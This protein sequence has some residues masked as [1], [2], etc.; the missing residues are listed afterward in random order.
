MCRQA[1]LLF[2]RQGTLVAQRFDLSRGEV[3]GDS[4]SVGADPV[5]FD[6]NFNFG[7]FSFRNRF[8]GVSHGS[9]SERR[10]LVWFDRNGKTLGTVG[11]P[12]DNR[13]SFPQISPDGHRVAVYR[14]VQDNTD[15]WILDG[16]RATRFTFDAALDRY[17]TWSP[18]GS[19][20]VFSSNRKGVDNL[21]IKPSS[22]ARP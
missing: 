12:D 20:I 15:A 4:I 2:I 9:S 18:D 1:R 5:G 21:Y 16:A 13:I 19:R 14:L 11:G 22:G 6:S 3:S 8:G 10:Q 17:A 7:V